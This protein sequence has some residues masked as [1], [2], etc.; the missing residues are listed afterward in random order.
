MLPATVMCGHSA[1]DWN[2]IAV[3]ALFGRQA[4]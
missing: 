1:Y 3:R 2:I 4:A